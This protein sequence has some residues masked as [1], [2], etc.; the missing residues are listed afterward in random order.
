MIE[1]R[2]AVEE[3]ELEI[4]RKQ[5]DAYQEPTNNLTLVAPKEIV[6]KRPQVAVGKLCT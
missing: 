3:K 2:N 4:F 6:T 5:R 1:K